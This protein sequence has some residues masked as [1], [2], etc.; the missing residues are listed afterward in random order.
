MLNGTRYSNS[1]V[2]IRC[3]NLSS[4]THLK[5]IKSVNDEKLAGF[6]APLP[7]PYHLKVEILGFL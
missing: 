2:Q 3:N 7:S 6:L 1:N 5:K 4:L